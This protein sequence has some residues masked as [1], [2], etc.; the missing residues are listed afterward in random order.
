VP[1]VITALFAGLLAVVQVPLTVMVGLQRL[2][3]D[4]HFL[5]GNDQTLLRRMRAHGNFTETVPITLIVMGLAELLGA[6]SIALWLGGISLVLGRTLHAAQLLRNGWG[7]GR[8]GGMILTFLPMAGF[9]LWCLTQ[10]AL[11]L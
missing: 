9:G 8:S 7:N 3:T 1:V 11:R 10:A 4:I 6:P 2:K 5:D